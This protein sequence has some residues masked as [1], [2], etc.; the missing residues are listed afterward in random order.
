VQISPHEGDGDIK[1]KW[2]I[3]LNQVARGGMIGRE[4]AEVLKLSLRHV[5][6]ILAAYRKESIAALA[7]CNR[8]RKHRHALEEGLKR[9]VLKL[10]Q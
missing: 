6:R 3:V 9:Q 8:G 1:K 10:A 4:A 5:R 7:H 2:V